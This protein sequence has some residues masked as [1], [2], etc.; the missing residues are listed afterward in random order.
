MLVVFPHPDD[1]SFGSGGTIAHYTKLGIPVTYV[2]LT[3]GEMGRNMGKPPFATRESLPQLRKQ[4][5]L[6]ACKILGIKDVRML[7]YRDKTIEFEDEAKLIKEI[8][9]IIVEIKPSLIITHYPGQSVHPDHDATGYVTIK[10]VRQLPE[11]EQ[12]QIYCIALSN[13]REKVLGKPNIVQDISETSDL[14][15]AAIK[16]HRS[17]TEAMLKDNIDQDPNF[18]KWL[19]KEEFWIYQL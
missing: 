13:G 12:P 15:A 3:L 5:L 1:E 4:E 9:E 8:K 10:A 18:N 7:G 6:Q 17:Q 11:T 2:C 16:A 14:K 19:M